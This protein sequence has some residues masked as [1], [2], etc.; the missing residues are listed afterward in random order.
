MN[1][2]DF[3]FPR[4]IN[5]HDTHKLHDWFRRMLLKFE[6]NESYDVY[7]NMISNR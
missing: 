7:D 3:G 1:I 4:F 6:T 2:L 5:S